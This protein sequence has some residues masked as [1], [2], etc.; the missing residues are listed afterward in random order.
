[1]PSESWLLGRDRFR[2]PAFRLLEERLMR[3]AIVTATLAALSLPAAAQPQPGPGRPPPPARPPQ[4]QP[5]PP[6]PPPPGMFPCRTEAETCHI[7]VAG[8]ANQMM[9]IFSSAPQGQA[10]EGKP[11]AVQGVDLGP[12]V[13]KVVMLTGELGPN[14]ITGAQV[15][16]V[17]GPLLSFLI[18]QNVGD[19]A[20]QAQ[21]PP[22][23]GGPPKPPGPPPPRR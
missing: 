5:Q 13:G 1:L 16:E 18:K 7:G 17:A 11:I 23:R 15:V 3:L 20:P 2:P 12:H 4:A 6:A 22:P 9:L 10:A 8:G 21:A 14:G 19:D